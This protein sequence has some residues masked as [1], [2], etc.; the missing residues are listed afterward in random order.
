MEI[1]EPTLYRLDSLQR[2]TQVPLNYA[3]DVAKIYLHLPN[4]YI[5][6]FDL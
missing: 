4:S 6:I 3:Q 1:I 2:S 5:V